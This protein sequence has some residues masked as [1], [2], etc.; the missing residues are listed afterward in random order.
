MFWASSIIPKKYLTILYT[1]T[2]GNGQPR[3]GSYSGS[4]SDVNIMNNLLEDI[5][6]GFPQRKYAEMAI[7]KVNLLYFSF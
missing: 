3:P 7:N 5:R 2:G 4:E 6:S 1:Q